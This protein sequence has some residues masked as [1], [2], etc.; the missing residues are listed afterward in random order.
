MEAFI[1]DKRLEFEK[2]LEI[3]EDGSEDSDDDNHAEVSS[4]ADTF[5][6]KLN[7]CKCTACTKYAEKFDNSPWTTIFKRVVDSNVSY[8]LVK[9]CLCP[10]QECPDLQFEAEET[11]PRFYKWACASSNCK[12][13]GINTLPWECDTLSQCNTCIPVQVWEDAKRTGDMTQLEIVDKVL[14]VCDIMKHLKEDLKIFMQHYVDIQLFRQMKDLDVEKQDPSTLLIF[15]D[16]AAMIDYR[17]NKT[18]CGHQ[19]H[20][21]VL[22]I[23]Y[24]LSKPRNVQIIQKEGE[25]I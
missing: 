24:V 5:Y 25:T 22:Q 23:F 20:H 2:L 3:E 12:R 11:P 1:Y 16:F 7:S 17:A 15:T 19:D 14:P 21:G 18:L 9:K 6:S 10:K 8:R 13:C 4:A